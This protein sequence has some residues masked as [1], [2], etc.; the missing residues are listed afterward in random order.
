[1]AKIPSRQFR[2]EPASQLSSSHSQIRSSIVQIPSLPPS[3]LNQFSQPTLFTSRRTDLDPALSQPRPD[4]ILHLRHSILPPS[5]SFAPPHH[6]AHCKHK[7]QR[8][9]HFRVC[10]T[11]YAYFTFS[12][13]AVSQQT[14]I[15]IQATNAITVIPP[16]SA[17]NPNSRFTNADN[18]YRR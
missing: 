16:T 14:C 12:S 8:G 3:S 9:R 13:A 5:T 11:V 17:H 15:I 2:R 6:A 1:M 7:A 18:T 4:I 10:F